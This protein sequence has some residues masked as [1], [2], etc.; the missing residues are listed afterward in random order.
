MAIT[1]ANDY[2]QTG[3]L[4]SY[5][6]VTLGGH[7]LVIKQVE[8]T[9][10]R[11]GK[12][13]LKISFDFDKNDSQAGY[14]EKAWKDDIRPEKTWKGTSYMMVLDN[15]GKTSKGF[16]TFCTC[17]EN[18]N[19][20]FKAWKADNSLNSEG[21]KGKKVGAVFGVQMDYY[22]GKEL[23]KHVLRW[24][25]SSDKVADAKIPAPTETAAYK[26]RPKEAPSVGDGFVNVPEGL[27]DELP[28]N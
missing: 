23:E 10:S 27:E 11:T 3:L 8:E 9:Q 13:M 6:P 22:E 4:G 25:V 18:S 17:L 1:K 21:M 5:E 28:F 2:E 20:G 16:K 15:E 14:F 24:F 7:H 26:N 19:T 12:D